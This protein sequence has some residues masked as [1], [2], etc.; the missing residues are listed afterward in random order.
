MEGAATE[1]TTAIHADC[2]PTPLCC[3]GYSSDEGGVVELTITDRALPKQVT[4]ATST[5]SASTVDNT[6]TLAV[7]STPGLGDELEQPPTNDT[8]AER[9]HYEARFFLVAWAVASVV[10]MGTAAFAA[11]AG[12]KVGLYL[13][14]RFFETAAYGIVDTG[15]TINNSLRA[16]GQ[17]LATDLRTVV[18]KR[19]VRWL[20]IGLLTGTADVLGHISIEKEHFDGDWRPVPTWQPLPILVNLVLFFG[21]RIGLV[22]GVMMQAH[23]DRRPS[24]MIWFVMT[25]ASFALS[26]IGQCS[27]YPLILALGAILSLLAPT[28][29]LYLVIMCV[30]KNTPNSDVKNGY[31][32][33]FGLAMWGIQYFTLHLTAFRKSLNVYVISGVLMAFQKVVL[34]IVEPVLKR[35]LGDDERKLWSFFVPACVLALELGPCLLLLGS[36]MAALEFWLL[37]VLQEANSVMKNTGKYHELYVVVRASLHRPVSEEDIKKMNERRKVIAP[38]DNLGEILSPIVILTALVLEGMFDILPIVRA[39]YLASSD[40]GILGGWKHRRFRGEGPIMMIVVLAVRVAF[41]WVEVTVRARQRRRAETGAV[42]ARGRR[43]SMVV[44]Y[45]RVVR[46][47]DAPI[48]MQR[49]AGGLLALQSLLFVCYAAIKGKVLM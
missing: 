43:S 15:V 2:V 47:R 48:Q 41:C 3:D 19:G 7:A 16:A 33:L 6:L 30:D 25:M 11:L 40:E 14:A 39:P 22:G 45:H 4:P 21:C 12:G 44:L 46:S 20:V 13:L 42:A 28:V 37:L 31:P 32:L 49:A 9:T 38:C 26:Y 29:G 23:R 18:V 35:F 34:K 36:D 17:P 1:E 24:M 5:R 8:N 10:G 27:P